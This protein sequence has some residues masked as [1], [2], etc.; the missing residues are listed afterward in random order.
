MSD[1]IEITIRGADKLKIALD[2]FPEM[3]KKIAAQAADEA[4]KEVLNTTGLQRYPGMSA[5]NQ[6]PTPYYIR[7]VGMQ[8]KSSN[9][10]KSEKYGTQFYVKHEGYGTVVGNRASY[11]RY[12]TDEND[13]ASHM[14]RL[15]WR[16]LIDVARE[17]IGRI[18][19]IYNKW[20]EYAID[21]LGL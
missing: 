7:G 8:Y 20:V 9:N 21:K 2:K 15:G 3:I 1:P 6:P 10:M 14:A 4:A 5:A 18:T 11:A 19:T 13:Q 17:K 12:L 16:K